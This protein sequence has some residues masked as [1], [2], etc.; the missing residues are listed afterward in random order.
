MTMT[1][2]ESKYFIHLEINQNLVSTMISIIDIRRQIFCKHDR[3]MAELDFIPYLVLK[4]VK[5]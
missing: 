1:V 3:Q 5:S 2:I 4:E